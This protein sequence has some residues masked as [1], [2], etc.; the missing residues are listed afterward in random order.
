MVVT[1]QFSSAQ[2]ANDSIY[3][4]D[5][6]KEQSVPFFYIKTGV[7]IKSFSMLANYPLPFFGIGHFAQ[8]DWITGTA[9]FVSEAGLYEI[10]SKFHEEAD[11]ASF[12]NYDNP[13]DRLYRNTKTSFANNSYAFITQGVASY[14][15]MIDFYSAY[16]GLHNKTSSINKV[17]FND[18]GVFS[19]VLSP[20]KP[21]YLFNPWVFV[22]V[23]SGA[24]L[25]YYF[26]NG[27]KP[28]SSA[29]NIMLFDKYYSPNNAAATFGAV[30]VPRYLLVA[31]GEEMFFRGAIQTELTE[32]YNPSIAIGTSSVLFG[33]Y[34]FKDGPQKILSATIAGI[35]F[36]YRY[37]NNGYDLGETIATHFWVDWINNLI[38]FYRNPRESNFVFG[39]NWKF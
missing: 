32:Q 17:T 29:Q 27:S 13:T 8:K 26:S 25:E 15:S 14:I 10:T 34:H 18:D 12:N 31:S 23:L 1:I 38:E 16:R 36:S 30:N 9:F 5:F 4:T 22:P 28:L 39:I 35:Y 19:L 7:F 11:K 2:S 37:K 6:K 24:A 3:H 20:F 33:L 21:K